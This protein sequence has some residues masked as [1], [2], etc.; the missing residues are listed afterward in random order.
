MAKDNAHITPE[1]QLLK[2][3]EEPRDRVSVGAVAKARGFSFLT[4]GVL[5]GRWAFAQE[6]LKHLSSAWRG[7]L[8]IKKINALLSVLAMAV[9]AYFIADTVLIS[10]RLSTVPSF[11]FKTDAANKGGLKNASSLK[12][13]DFYTQK[14][15]A[16]DLF[17]I[18]LRA[19]EP[20]AANQGPDL[21]AQ[22]QEFLKKYKLVGI[23]W[24]DNPDAM[25]EDT[26]AQKTYFMKR[27]QELDGVKI[28][29]I[30]K[31]KVVLNYMNREIE[32]R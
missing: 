3:I 16:R 21:N 5:W 32:L 29:A 14:A 26:T 30:F 24:S 13:V 17:K 22:A 7:P 28:Q 1:K 2:L 27:G 11:S 31:D 23:S 6:K 18:G 19:P 20:E 4:P 25:I 12:S 10:L 15:Q 9:G 8:D